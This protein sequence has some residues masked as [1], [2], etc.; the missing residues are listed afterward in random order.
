MTPKLMTAEEAADYLRVPVR[1]LYDWRLKKAGPPAHKVGKYLR[2][3]P[4][5]I[6][7]W[8]CGALNF[9]TVDHRNSPGVER[10]GGLV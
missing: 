1:T 10:G 5:E 9:P 7:R 3:R 6:S 2:Y 8:C 4:E